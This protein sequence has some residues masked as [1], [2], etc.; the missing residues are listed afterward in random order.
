MTRL[1]L[2]I[3][4]DQLTRWGVSCFTC[5]VFIG[6][7]FLSEHKFNL[8]KTLLY[9][10]TLAPHVA[11]IWGIVKARTGTNRLSFASA[12]LGLSPIRWWGPMVF[13]WWLGV[14]L[15]IGVKLNYSSFVSKPSAH[16][17]SCRWSS[18]EQ[19]RWI[20]KKLIEGV[21]FMQKDGHLRAWRL[22]AKG[23]PE[24]LN[25][26]Q[27][28]EP[29]VRIQPIQGWNHA[30]KQFLIRL[31]LLTLCL[32]SVL[33]ISERWLSLSSLL[34]YPVICIWELTFLS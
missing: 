11:L 22:D 19:S 14:S 13:V 12:N 32:M 6:I 21:C 26:S 2:M 10:L 15:S 5:W 16:I 25:P 34:L 24:K 4:K 17:W 27:L 33:L 23:S 31:P 29:M 20:S 30:L 7:T 1:T 18:E 28:D 9:S 3:L 8:L